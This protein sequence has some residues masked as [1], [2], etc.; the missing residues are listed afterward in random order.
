M[1]HSAGRMVESRNGCHSPGSRPFWASLVLPT[2]LCREGLQSP[3][4]QTL[5]SEPGAPP[6]TKAFTMRS[7]FI[8]PRS[9]CQTGHS[10]LSNLHR[11][12]WCLHLGALT[13]DAQLWLRQE[14]G[15]QRHHSSDCSQGTIPRERR[16][17]LTDDRRGSLQGKPAKAA[18]ELGRVCTYALGL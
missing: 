11:E 3:A 15:P 1:E 8:V 7:R 9:G 13:S 10:Q 16:T 18:R 17:F 14:H 2:E 5:G 4:P 6:L 12:H